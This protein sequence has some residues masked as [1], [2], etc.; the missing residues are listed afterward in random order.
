MK[1]LAPVGLLLVLL[2]APAAQAQVV[3]GYSTIAPTQIGSSPVFDDA[4]LYTVQ[5]V[6]ADREVRSAVLEKV[7]E[8]DETRSVLRPPK[9]VNQ[10]VAASYQQPARFTPPSQ[11][12]EPVP[13]DLQPTAAS[14][15]EY[16]APSLGAQTV[17]IQASATLPATPSGA[18]CNP[19]VTC[20]MPVQQVPV[21]QTTTTVVPQQ[22]S[23]ASI[24]SQ[25]PPNHFF[26]R[27]L[28]GQPVV[29]VE[30]QPLRNFFRFFSP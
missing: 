23:V 21:A 17:P 11:N 30:S 7:R 19:C 28:V 4:P 2:L 25:L 5:R 26:G 29:Y 13:V 14:G 3:G 9:H 12:L 16:Y 24:P 6:D 20:C 27:G 10:V 18:C 22:V 15:A 1:M 8:V